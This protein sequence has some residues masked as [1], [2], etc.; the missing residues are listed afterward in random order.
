LAAFGSIGLAHY[1]SRIASHYTPVTSRGNGVLKIGI[2]LG[3][4]IG[5]EVVPESVKVLKAAAARTGLQIEWQ[6]LPIGKRGHELHGNTLPQITVDAL[7]KTDGWICGPIGHNAYPRGDPTWVMPPLRK[8]FELFA[9]IKP[10]KSYP[11]IPSV[12]KD[13]DIVF[14]RE[15]TEGM[16]S[17]SVVV[18]GS[19]EFQPNDEIAIGM[20]VVTRKGASRVAREAFEIA[21]TRRRRMVTALHKEPVYR[22]V[23]GMFAREC[24]KVA[25]E[26]P[27]VE[28]NEV[29]IDGFA[30][31][32]VMK[33]QQYDVV[34]TTNQFGD[35]VTDEGAGLVGGLGLAPGLV[36][37]ERQAM[38]QATHG[39]A[40]DI[41]GRGIANPYAMIM[42]GMMLVEWLGR[43]RGEERATQAA[44]LIDAAMDKVIA[45]GK[46]LTPDLGGNAS[47][48]EM[49]SAVAA[50]L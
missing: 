23:C 35:I 30:L 44:K 13:V 47:T 38:A 42:S 36:V 27:D 45:E 8:K 16:M 6:E 48:G 41:A 19:G 4:D 17:G 18:A 37:G 40:P 24:R 32:L 14:L 50:N 11:N 22:L 9:N 29:L 34:V 26:F 43:K 1:Q 25:A 39:S 46:R 49:G 5:L 12:H 33:P 31:K 3:D 21:R 28:F 10:V 20:R 7:A 15:T 2:L